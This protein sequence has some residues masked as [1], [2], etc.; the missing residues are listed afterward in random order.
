ME[1]EGAAIT[2]VFSVQKNLKFVAGSI[3]PA[4]LA[5][6]SQNWW[7]SATRKTVRRES[8]GRGFEGYGLISTMDF[9]LPVVREQRN[10]VKSCYEL[11]FRANLVTE[12]LPSPPRPV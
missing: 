1:A 10:T 6:L 8:R 11:D 4:K 12:L 3:K 9:R 2:L 7:F 5:V